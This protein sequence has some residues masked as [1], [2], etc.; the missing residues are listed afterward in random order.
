MNDL[1][2]LISIL[3]NANSEN[4]SIR[5]DSENQIMEMLNDP[6]NFLLQLSHVI[7]VSNIQ[8]PV[9]HLS[10]ILISRMLEPHTLNELK[11]IQNCFN[12]NSNLSESLK[13]VFK[14]RKSDVGL[15]EPSSILKAAG[16]TGLQMPKYIGLCPLLAIFKIQWYIV[17]PSCISPH[18]NRLLRSHNPE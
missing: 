9:I 15:T 18:F 1:S 6:P 5:R 17:G 7:N 12:S 3:L 2:N 13:N 4:E 14:V 8:L 11:Q 10:L 16:R